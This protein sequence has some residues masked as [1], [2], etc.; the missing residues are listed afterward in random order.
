MKQYEVK[1]ELHVS[2]LPQDELMSQFE[3]FCEALADLDEINPQMD[4][5]GAGFDS[6]KG[7]LDVQLYIDS[8]YEAAA[9]ADAYNLIRTA[10]HAAGGSTPSWGERNGTHAFYEDGA[11]AIPVFA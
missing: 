7:L 11:N 2:G 6:G 10:I 3:D 4:S 5:W 1:V 8:E 9:V